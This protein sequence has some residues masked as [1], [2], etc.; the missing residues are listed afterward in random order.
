MSRIVVERIPEVEPKKILRG[1]GR[2]RGSRSHWRLSGLC[3]AGIAWKSDK[4][5]QQR[6]SRKIQNDYRENLDGHC[7]DEHIQRQ[8]RRDNAGK[9]Y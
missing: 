7:K 3:S 4:T 5:T 6:M 1:V 8:S 9:I 2:N